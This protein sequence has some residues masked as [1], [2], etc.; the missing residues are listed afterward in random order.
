MTADNP[1]F[2]R[3]MALAKAIAAGD[4]EIACLLKDRFRDEGGKVPIV[5]EDMDSYTKAMLALGKYDADK[6]V[7][8]IE[9]WKLQH[10]KGEP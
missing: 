6:I 8:T 2:V 5:G 4:Y 7:K 9:D 1:T 10:P 3:S